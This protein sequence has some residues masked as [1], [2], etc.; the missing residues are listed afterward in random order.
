MTRRR[1][2]WIGVAVFVAFWMGTSSVSLATVILEADVSALAQ[3]SESVVH[4]RVVDIRSD[5]ND[6]QTMIFTHVTLDVV[7]TL[8]GQHQNQVVVRVP[9]GSVDGFT[10][11]MPG[12]PRFS[13]GNVVV[14]LGSWDDGI[15]RVVGYFQGLSQVVP[16]RLGNLRLQGGSANGLSLPQLAK[17]VRPAAS[18]GR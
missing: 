17:R 3:E 5:W 18:R 13:K 16:D 10:V 1:V 8:R 4:A 11:D 9:G 14:F 7:R 6:E 12:A 15:A 2:G